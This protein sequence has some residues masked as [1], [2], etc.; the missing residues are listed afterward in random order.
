MRALWT[1][2]VCEHEAL[3]YDEIGHTCKDENGN[4]I[5]EYDE[6][7]DELVREPNND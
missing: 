5:G 3:A 7:G 4:E 1:C 6:Q 2:H